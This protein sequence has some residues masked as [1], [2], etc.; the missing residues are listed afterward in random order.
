MLRTNILVESNFFKKIMFNGLFQKTYN[1]ISF[2]DV[3]FIIKSSYNTDF[4]II[5]TLPITE[6]DCL[7]KN[8]ISYDSEEKIINELM[9]KY[10]FK[11]YKFIIYGKHSNDVSIETKGKQLLN[12]GFSNVYVYLGGLFEWMLL[13]DI[14]GFD[15]FPTTKKVLDILKFKPPRTFETK[16]L[17]L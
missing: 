9:T 17:L 14:Y 15:E 5:N 10:E 4:I 13:Q 8:T 12:L 6:Q 3:Q 2:E 11:K 7:I 16:M 1:K